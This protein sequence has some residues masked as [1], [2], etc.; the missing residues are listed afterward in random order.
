MN[1]D[2]FCAASPQPRI[3][4]IGLRLCFLTAASEAR[5]RAAA[6]SDSGEAF[7]GV[8]VPFP[9]LKTGLR[10]LVLDSLNWNKSD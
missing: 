5:T 9:G 7:A 6:P 10:V 2:G 1:L 3:L 4:A 8:T